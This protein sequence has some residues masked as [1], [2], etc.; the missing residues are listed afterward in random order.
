VGPGL[1]RAHDDDVRAVARSCPLPIVID[2]D[3][4]T[5]LGTDLDVVR[6]AVLTPHDGEYARL[7]GD[8]PGAD[9][10][11]AARALAARAG[12]VAVLKGEAMVVAA[13]DGDVLVASRGDARLATAGTGDVLTGITVALLAQGLDPFLA[14]ATAAHLLGAAADLGWRRGL[15]AGD[16]AALLPVVL[17]GL[18]FDA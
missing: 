13:P 3:G 6:H 5:A 2:G 12:A 8:P 15:V 17:E 14:A 7:M 18:E 4:L 10:I 16:V 1:G 11:G 9:R